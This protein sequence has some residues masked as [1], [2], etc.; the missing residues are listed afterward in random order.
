MGKRQAGVKTKATA[1][2]DTGRIG[3]IK[4]D[5]DWDGHAIEPNDR[6]IEGSETAATFRF[7]GWATW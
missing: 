1:A 5:L 6:R 3:A 7:S 2:D 4:D